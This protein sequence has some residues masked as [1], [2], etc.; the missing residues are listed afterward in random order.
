MN[1]TDEE[2]FAVKKI[3]RHMGDKLVN[4]SKAL[5]NSGTAFLMDIAGTIEALERLLEAGHRSES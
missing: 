2:W 5:D 3:R 4:A 1:L